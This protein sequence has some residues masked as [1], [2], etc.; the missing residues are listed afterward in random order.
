MFKLLD[1][2]SS[3]VDQEH[4]RANTLVP[5]A[6]PLCTGAVSSRG[7]HLKFWDDVSLTHMRALADTSYLHLY[8]GLQSAPYAAGCMEGGRVAFRSV[9]HHLCQYAFSTVYQCT[10][11]HIFVYKTIYIYIYICYPPPHRSIDFRLLGR[12]RLR[13]VS[14]YLIQNAVSMK[15][16]CTGC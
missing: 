11:I 9:G 7:G 4:A 5:G 2:A 15:I 3:N 16:H 1:S 6:G 13:V 14:N 10:Y 8:T 12:G